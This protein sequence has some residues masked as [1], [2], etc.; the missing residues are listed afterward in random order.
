[1]AEIAFWSAA[2]VVA[3][4]WVGYPLLLSLAG[5]LVRQPRRSL[6][7]RPRL[8][9]LIAAYNE[10]HCIE[11][12]LESTLAQRYPADRL[13][14]IVISDGSSDG[15][16][17]IVARHPDRRVRLVRQEPRAGKSLALNLG[18]AAATGEILVFTDA[19]A[20]F[21][22]DA[23]ARLAA[24]FHD[25]RVGLV[26]GQG[27]YGADAAGGDTSRAVGNGYVRYEALIKRG[28]S[29]LGFVAGADGAIYALRRRLFQP[30]AP[31]EVNDLVHPIQAALA[32]HTSRFDPHAITVE[33]PSHDASQEFR[34]HVRIIAQ[35][36]DALDEWWPRLLR[37]RR[38]RAAWALLSHR[39]LR[40]LTAPLLGVVLAASVALASSHPFYAAALAL[41][42]AFYAVAGAG[43]LAER[44]AI[45]LG[46]LALPYYFCVVVTAGIAGLVRSLRRGGEAVWSPAG[47][48]AAARDRA[49]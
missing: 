7:S 39:L 23:L 29:A 31:A 32:G 22:P 33:P 26:S 35:G 41:Q 28:E 16:D 1:M 30:L 49:A 38:W 6:D 34:R 5:R 43:L 13:E 42:A 11:A 36:F 21:G 48:E 10:A 46:P 3:Y 18:A 20:L 44:R 9:V 14:V 24:A 25:P 47:R 19:N 17:G 12:K 15:T 27:L 8:S 40:W 2:V 37:A 45:A 4:T